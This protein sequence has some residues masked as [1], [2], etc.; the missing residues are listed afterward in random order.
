LEPKYNGEP[1][2]V[3]AGVRAILHF[4]LLENKIIGQVRYQDFEDKDGFSKYM[5]MYFK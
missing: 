1:D 2:S 5:V 3:T 4:L